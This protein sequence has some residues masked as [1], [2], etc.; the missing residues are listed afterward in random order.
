M[1]L[2]QNL[3]ISIVTSSLKQRKLKST[4][5]VNLSNNRVLEVN[6]ELVELSVETLKHGVSQLRF[7]V[8]NLCCLILVDKSPYLLLSL[9]LKHLFKSLWT[10]MVNKVDR[11][12]LKLLRIIKVT[13]MECER[14]VYGDANVVSRRTV[15]NRGI[16][17]D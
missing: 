1:C 5:N 9:A 4:R 13:D 16:K 3:Q 17:P 14:H 11:I 2:L 10:Q 15:L 12:S 6:S 8:T 7:N